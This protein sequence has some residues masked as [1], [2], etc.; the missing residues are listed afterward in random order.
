MFQLKLLKGKTL[1]FVDSV[2][3]A[4]ELRLL[5]SMFSLACGVLNP[6]LPLNTRLAVMDRFNKSVS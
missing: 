5:L 1:I 4:Y 3:T 2:Q 6:Q